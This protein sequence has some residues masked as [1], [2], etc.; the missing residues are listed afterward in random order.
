MGI[1]VAG[2]TFGIFC[3]K[4]D[5]VRLVVTL[6]AVGDQPVLPMA[7]TAVD[8]P[9]F[10]RSLGPQAIDCV[11][12]AGADLGIHLRGKGDLQRHVDGMALGAAFLGLLLIMGFVAFEAGRDVP[13]FFVV[14]GGAFLLGVPAGVLGQLSG[15]FTVAVTA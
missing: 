5:V 13:V 3:V 15:L 14:A 11:M 6:A 7:L 8:A 4:A 10:R 12:T 9:V 1:N 2:Q